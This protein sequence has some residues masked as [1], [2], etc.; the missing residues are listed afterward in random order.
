MSDALF[1]NEPV[2]ST[3]YVADGVSISLAAP[4]KR[5]SLRARTAEALETV[6]NAKV[7]QKI[8]TT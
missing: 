6:L 3:P 8:G 2:S 4:L 5:Y 1:R 7:P